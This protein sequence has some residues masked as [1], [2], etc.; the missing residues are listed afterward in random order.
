[1]PTIVNIIKADNQVAIFVN[2][3]FIETKDWDGSGER[4]YPIDITSSLSSTATNFVVIVGL[5][6]GGPHE[7]LANV[8]HNGQ[9][10]H[11]VKDWGISKAPDPTVAIDGY[12]SPWSQVF[13]IPPVAAV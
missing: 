8:K 11:P 2:R 1:M 9:D 3:K 4:N 10:I 13:R 7:F 12:G 5:N 6:W